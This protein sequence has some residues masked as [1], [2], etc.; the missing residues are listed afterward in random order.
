MTEEFAIESDGLDVD[1]IMREIKQRVEKKKS[2]GVYD[3]YNLEGLTVK[4][5]Q[6]IKNEGDFLNYYIELIQNTC[7]IDIGDFQIPSKG[8]IFGRPIA[9]LKRFVWIM[10]R[11][12]TYR[13]FSQQKE[14]NFQLVNTLI[15]INKK[16]DGRVKELEDRLK[17]FEDKK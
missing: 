12:Y 2:A 3:K 9:K 11:F 16:L 15:S 7:D 10:L 4:D 6:Q 5:I 1:S 14:F 8:G 17:Q 13:L